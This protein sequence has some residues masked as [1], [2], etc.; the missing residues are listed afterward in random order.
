[1]TLILAF[2][3]KFFLGNRLL[4]DLDSF[5][6][7]HKRLTEEDKIYKKIVHIKFCRLKMWSL[8]DTQ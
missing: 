5:Y 1:M 3:I 4:T 2:L 7:C 8:L 6:K